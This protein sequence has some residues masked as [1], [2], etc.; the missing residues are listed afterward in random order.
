MTIQFLKEFFR[1]GI[2]NLDINKSLIIPL[3]KWNMPLNT[4]YFRL[5]SS[6]NV[7]YKIIVKI[8]IARMRPLLDKT[9]SPFHA[10]FVPKRWIIEHTI[11]A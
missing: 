2:L 1:I 3:Q 5:I 11:I 8:L 4:T 10:T 6:C 7:T 9:I